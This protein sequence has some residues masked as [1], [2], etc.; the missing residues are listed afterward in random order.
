MSRRTRSHTPARRDAGLRRLQAIN[1]LLIGGA[2][3][4]TGLLTDVAA[5]AFPG[6]SRVIATAATAGETAAGAGTVTSS[7][8][9]GSHRRHRVTAPAQA[10]AATSTAPAGTNAAGTSTAPASTSTQPAAT[11]TQPAATST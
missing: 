6:H 10:P 11:G 7:Q 5:Q 2:V 4:A 3:A 8:R 1:R 9:H